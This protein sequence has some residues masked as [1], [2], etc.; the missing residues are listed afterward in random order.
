MAG[1]CGHRCP[2]KP[3]V[4]HLGTADNTGLFQ[5]ETLAPNG[6]QKM[7]VSLSSPE[8]KSSKGLIKKKGQGIA[9]C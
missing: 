6:I 5:Q 4:Q 9:A 1:I 2:P 8:P 7:R 3:L